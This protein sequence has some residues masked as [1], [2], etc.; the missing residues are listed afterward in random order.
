M[1]RPLHIRARWRAFTLLELSIVLAVVSLIAGVGMSIATNSLKAADRITTQ[2]KLAVIKSAL[3]SHAQSYGYLPCPSNLTLV[4][5]SSSFGVEA[6][7]GT[8]CTVSAPGL[9]GVA[10]NSVFIGSVPVRT[11][12]LP[13]HY[14]ADAWGG[15][16]TYAVSAPLAANAISYAGSGSTIAV[17]FGTRASNYNVTQERKSLP[18]SGV[19]SNGGIARLTLASTVGLA[20]GMSVHVGGTVYKGQFTVANLVANTSID[21]TGS[22]WSATDTGTVEWQEVGLGAAFV[23][24]SHGPDGRGAFPLAGSNVPATKLCTGVGA[25]TSP[26]PCTSSGTTT[27]IDIENCNNSD[28]IFFDTAYKES[29]TAANY[30]DDFIVWGSNALKRT[31]VSQTLYPSCPTGVCEA[32]CAR[33]GTN[34]P[35]GGSTAPPTGLTNPSLCKKIINTNAATC[36]ATCF[37]SGTTGTGYVECP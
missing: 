10:T 1:S 13:D 34:Y 24:V 26:P 36:S 32:W 27:C 18:Y 23:V 12:G 31:A 19:T 14:A 7:S 16:F 5:T 15:K 25:N 30:F 28:E 37:W 2:E 3:E 35:N 11:L 33:C 17:R 6:R 22:T 9:V 4:S 8:S 20:N 21:L 29:G